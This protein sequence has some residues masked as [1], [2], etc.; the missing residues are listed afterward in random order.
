MR[1]CAMS[2]MCYQVVELYQSTQKSAHL[3]K[4]GIIGLKEIAGEVR[5]DA[6]QGN[7][8]NSCKSVQ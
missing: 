3:D 4:H 8:G 7:A 1:I 5:K 2:L 6:E